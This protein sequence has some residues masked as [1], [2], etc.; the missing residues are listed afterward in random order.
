MAQTNEQAREIE[1]CIIASEYAGK[2]NLFSITEKQ[3]YLKK[4]SANNERKTNTTYKCK[5]KNCNAQ[6]VV[7]NNRCQRKINGYKHNHPEIDDEKI[8]DMKTMEK[9]RQKISSLPKGRIN[10]KTILSEYPDTEAKKYKQYI[11][12]LQRLRNKKSIDASFTSK[13]NTIS[14]YKITKNNE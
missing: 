3:L 10:W 8:E 1:Y 4:S 11:R 9:F 6:V 13:T 7:E 12:S 14:K 2:T 5:V